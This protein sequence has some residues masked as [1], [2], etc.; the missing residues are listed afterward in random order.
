MVLRFAR[1]ARF[2]RERAPLSF[3]Y[4]GECWSGTTIPRS[5]WK[6]MRDRDSVLTSATTIADVPLGFVQEKTSLTLFMP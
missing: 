4:L 6:D 5:F 1:F 3:L 2:A